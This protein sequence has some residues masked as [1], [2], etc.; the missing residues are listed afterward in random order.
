MEKILQ[1]RKTDM[2]FV[3]K[4]VSK[5]V[6]LLNC[7]S[8]IFIFQ[9]TFTT[10]AQTEKNIS[11]DAFE[12]AEKIISYEKNLYG[13]SDD[14]SLLSGEFSARAGQSPAD[15]FVIG[16]SRLGINEDYESYYFSLKNNIALRYKQD[17]KLDADK[18]TE[19]H[20]IILSTVACGED[21]SDIN[22]I[23]LL[24]DGI[25]NRTEFTQGLNGY[26]WALIA[27]DSCNWKTPDKSGLNRDKIIKTILSAQLDDGS[28][29]LAG[30]KGNGD[31]DI[32]AMALQALAPY[33]NDRDTKIKSACENALDYLSGKQLPDGSY[34]NCES[35]AQV[36]TAIC[37]LGTD[38]NSD[39]RF[40]KSKNLY[41]ALTDYQNSD[42]G[43]SHIK[44]ENSSELPSAQALIALASTVRYENSLRRVFD[45]NEE[46]SESERN[47]LRNFRSS[48][49]DEKSY[50]KL[51]DRL[52]GYVYTQKSISGNSNNFTADKNKRTDAK[53]YIFDIRKNQR[54][55]YTQNETQK[56]ISELNKKIMNGLYP[57]DNISKENE[58]EIR[59]IYKEASKLSESDQNKIAGFKEL[60]NAYKKISHSHSMI[61]I[62]AVCIFCIVITVSAVFTVKKRS[63]KSDRNNK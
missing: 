10:S 50:S 58:D 3:G 31:V 54:F 27:L 47:E 32:T 59:Q 8:M 52:K 7:L 22:N 61:W 11:D 60:E 21:P 14:S 63:K 38:Y 49:A 23:N 9:F 5:I 15:W 18:A 56:K 42:G 28:F 29:S 26:E 25:Y 17:E 19:W 53:G 41:D 39:N 6:A 51:S 45:F 44:G 20:R 40:I 55:N 36:L 34:G 13:I 16:C 43:F 30:K 33:I 37:S 46:F 1:E 62:I 57:F 2:T 12:C 4:P 24:A 35:T 48:N